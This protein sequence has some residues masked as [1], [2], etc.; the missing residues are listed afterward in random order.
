RRS[1]LYLALW[2]LDIWFS[3]STRAGASEDESAIPTA[4]FASTRHSSATA[5]VT[6]RRGRR[7]VCPPAPSESRSGADDGRQAVAP[8]EQVEA[9]K[10][11]PQRDAERPV[12]GGREPVGGALSAGVGARN[13]DVQ[14]SVAIVLQPGRP[15][16]D[17]E[18]VDGIGG[19]EELPVAGG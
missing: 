13:P 14:R 19:E 18:A 11:G 17:R 16:A 9:R 12:R 7:G 15:I 5:R 10:I 2:R 4:A 8:I 3:S 1:S 6:R